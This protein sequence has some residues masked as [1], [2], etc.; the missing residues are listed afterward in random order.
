MTKQEIKELLN[1]DSDVRSSAASNPNTPVEALTELSKDSDWN[2]RRRAA[3]NPNTPVEALTELSKDSDWNVRSSAASNPNTPVEALTE[4]SK[5]N[6]SDVRSSAASN[7]NTPHFIDNREFT[8]TNTYVATQGTSHLWYKHKGVA[9]PF[10][11]CGCFIGNREQL[12]SR[13][14]YDGWYSE[15]MQILSL[16]DKKFKDVF[17]N[18]NS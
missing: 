16:L 9:A 1:S 14:I 18:G 13:I 2:V 4:L 17:E 10:Y 6:D 3:S 5:D 7:P 8:I 15:R 12:I 11:T